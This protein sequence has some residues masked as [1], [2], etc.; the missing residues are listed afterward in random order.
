MDMRL[1]FIGDSIVAGSGDDE[2]RGWVG[3][4]GSA[5]R[6]SGVDHTP[7]NLGIGGNTAADVLARWEDE[8]TRRLNPE[9]DNRLVVQV[10]VNDARDGVE[11]DHDDCAR[12]LASFIE[13]ARGAGLE[14]LVVGPIPTRQSDESERI[15][16]LSR[17]FGEVCADRKT[18]FIEVHAAL[19]DSN[20][21]LASLESDGYHPDAEGYAA[22]AQVVLHNG[23]WEWLATRA[24]RQPAR[25]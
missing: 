1:I 19:R 24:G 13:G 21:F 10:G 7:Y 4:V 8:V 23:W 20:A 22:I 9:I 15:G 25:R 14:P 12:D 16:A 3:R 2:C 5:T 18:A 11:R 6:R 17:R